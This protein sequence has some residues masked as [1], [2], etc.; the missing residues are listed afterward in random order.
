MGDGADGCGGCFLKATMAVSLL[1]VSW[2]TV[3]DAAVS[4]QVGGLHTPR[5]L[6]GF[7][8]NNDGSAVITSILAS[9]TQLL[10]FFVTFHLSI[11]VSYFT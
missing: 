8:C 9:I 2:F 1:F 5:A 3:I 7:L 10:L 11:P 6:F 4:I